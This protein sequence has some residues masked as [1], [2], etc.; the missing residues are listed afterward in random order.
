[1]HYRAPALTA[2]A[3]ATV[4]SLSACSG[5][6][7]KTAATSST[8]VTNSSSVSS[9]APSSTSSRT[10][11]APSASATSS[12]STTATPAVTKTVQAAPSSTATVIKSADTAA[13]PLSKGCYTSDGKKLFLQGVSCEFAQNA[14]N[15]FK[16]PGVADDLWQAYSPVKHAN[17][18]F[19]CSEDGVKVVSCGG[20][21]M[22]PNSMF[23]WQD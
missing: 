4:L 13:A 1:M 11:S 8:T 22:N 15:A 5:G 14:Y 21:N 10:T 19:S 9:S 23:S 2:M 12:V 7:T 17:Y 20:G 6:D 16:G 18:T 3:F